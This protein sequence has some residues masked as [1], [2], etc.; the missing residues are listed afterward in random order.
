[1]LV[2][3]LYFLMQ[4]IV[5]QFLDRHGRTRTMGILVFGPLM[6]DL[7]NFFVFHFS[8]ILPGKYWWL[9][10]APVIEGMLGSMSSYLGFAFNN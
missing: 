9:I 10:I 3:V 1:M 2:F 4:T 6:S 8:D 5:C 7:L